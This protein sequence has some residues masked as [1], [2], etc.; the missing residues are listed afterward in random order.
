MPWLGPA[1]AAL[2]LLLGVGAAAGQW[3]PAQ[4]DDPVRVQAH[5]G[6]SGIE[7]R[8]RI[9]AGWY[10]YGVGAAGIGLPLQVLSARGEGRLEL[11]STTAP[12][13]IDV[14]GESVPIH[15][16]R[17]DLRIEGTPEAV[18]GR[19]RVRWAACRADLCIPRESRVRVAGPPDGSGRRPGRLRERRRRPAAI[20]SVD[21]A[22]P[23]RPHTL[24][25][26]SPCPPSSPW[27]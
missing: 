12:E 4:P 22:H 11:A 24:P 5:R 13:V 6:A 23:S 16:G 2:A 10:V 19:L 8:L 18:G 25:E 3:R 1:G 26:A 14:E 27:P 21:P 7:V 9:E 15:R 20:F 17:A